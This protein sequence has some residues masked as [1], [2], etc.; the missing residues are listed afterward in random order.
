[1]GGNRLGGPAHALH[2]WPIGSREEQA[3][4][5]SREEQAGVGSWAAQ[6]GVDGAR[7]V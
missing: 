3:G 7:C 2:P 1:M 6:A 5:R 4:V